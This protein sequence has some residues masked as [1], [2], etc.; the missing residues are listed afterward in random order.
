MEKDALNS[1]REKSELGGLGS[2]FPTH[3]RSRM[4]MPECQ[5][6]WDVVDKNGRENPAFAPDISL[7]SDPLGTYRRLGPDH[8]DAT[9]RFER[10]G[11]HVVPALACQNTAVP[12]DTPSQSLKCRC[13]RS[14]TVAVC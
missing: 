12:P 5:W 14:D 3:E 2:S 11:D 7:D 6:D 1:I 4:N 13:D 8:H 9:G 10:L